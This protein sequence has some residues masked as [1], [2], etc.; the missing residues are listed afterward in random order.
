MYIV[1]FCNFDIYKKNLSDE[2]N[3]NLEKTKNKR[4]EYCQDLVK[5]TKFRE[6]HLKSENQTLYLNL[7]VI[8][9]HFVLFFVFVSFSQ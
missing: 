8:L 5:R 9:F 6:N 2:I 4:L 7:L 1:F 3:S